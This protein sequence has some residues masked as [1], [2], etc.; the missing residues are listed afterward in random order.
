[1]GA[2]NVHH[3]SCVR[4]RRLVHASRPLCGRGDGKLAVSPNAV[5]WSGLTAVGVV[6]HRALDG[7]VAEERVDAVIVHGGEIDLEFAMRDLDRETRKAR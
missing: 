3:T 6:A 4:D 1:M 5:S 2:R 7:L